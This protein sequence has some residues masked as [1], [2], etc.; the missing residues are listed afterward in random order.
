MYESFQRAYLG[1]Y[2]SVPASFK[3]IYF[4]S[5]HQIL[6][7]LEICRPSKSLF[8]DVLAKPYETPVPGYGS[9]GGSR[10]SNFYPFRF[11]DATEI[12]TSHLALRDSKSH[13]RLCENNKHQLLATTGAD[14]QPLLPFPSTRRRISW[15]H[16]ALSDSRLIHLAT[17]CHG[18][19]VSEIN[20]H[21]FQV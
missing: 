6:A 14:A 10:S 1:G 2:P 19:V 7:T 12:T 13:R 11:P 20:G 3:M 9:A 18:F 4:V 21:H 17:P 16:A 15:H 5:L 8:V